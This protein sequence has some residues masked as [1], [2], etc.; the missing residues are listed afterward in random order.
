MAGISYPKL[1]TQEE[2]MQEYPT[3]YTLEEG[4][5]EYPAYTHEVGMAVHCIEEDVMAL[6]SSTVNEREGWQKYPVHY[7]R[8]KD[9]RNILL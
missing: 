9:G 1:Y 4:W 8:G 5:Q 2:G 3:L 7:T 6:V